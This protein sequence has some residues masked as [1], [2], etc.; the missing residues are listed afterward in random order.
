MNYGLSNGEYYAV[1]EEVIGQMADMEWQ[2]R[3]WLRQE[4]EEFSSFAE[5]M[6]VWFGELSIQQVLAGDHPYWQLPPETVRII[7]PVIDAFEAYVPPENDDYNHEAILS[8]PAWHAVCKLAAK[9][10]KKLTSLQISH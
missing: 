8:D 6:G 9:A 5:M 2:Q 10:Q 4:G 7:T 1:V 3:V